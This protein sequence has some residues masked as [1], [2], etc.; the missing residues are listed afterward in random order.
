MRIIFSLLYLIIAFIIQK[1][2]TESL[3]KIPV[4][5]GSLILKDKYPAS[6]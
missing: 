6:H 1:I 2:L 3:K 5:R 4:P